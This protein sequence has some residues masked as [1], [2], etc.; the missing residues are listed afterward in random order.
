MSR[1]GQEEEEEQE[2]EDQGRT[3]NA[4]AE[5]KPADTYDRYW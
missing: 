1:S 3:S 4:Y 2:E 5:K